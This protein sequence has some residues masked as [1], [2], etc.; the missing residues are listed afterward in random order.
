M[1]FTSIKSVGQPA[2]VPAMVNAGGMT[3]EEFTSYL[4]ETTGSS[5]RAPKIDVEK[6]MQ[7]PTVFAAVNLVSNVVASC[8][9]TLK[10][11]E[12]KNGLRK[13]VMVHE[14]AMLD[15]VLSPN[16]YQSA[17]DFVKLITTHLMLAGGFLAIKQFAPDGKRVVA[18]QPIKPGRWRIATDDSYVPIFHVYYQDRELPYAADKVVYIGNMSL[19]GVSNFTNLD[20]LRSAVGLSNKLSE[21][22]Y[23]Y[24]S[25]GNL[26]NGVLNI[27]GKADRAKLND[28]GREFDSAYSGTT[29]KRTAVFDDTVSFEPISAS[30]QDSQHLENRDHQIAEIA[31]IWNIPP[32]ML[33][34]GIPSQAAKDHFV[35]ECIKPLFSAI[36]Q[37]LTKALKP[38]FS[39]MRRAFF[40]LDETDLLRGSMSE[41]ASYIMTLLGSGGT[42]PVISQNEG[43]DYLNLELSD[44]DHAQ[45]ILMG[46]YEGANQGGLDASVRSLIKQVLAEGK[47]QGGSDAL[48]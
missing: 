7:N 12:S 18:L 26:I 40:D 22:S 46:G 33:G 9:I 37:G 31:S 45:E 20:V 47:P 14:H 48:G 3:I 5:E 2:S 11:V 39:D 19:D 8:P 32:E 16:P 36:E 25:K 10:K 27:K 17:F 6:A 4:I 28:Y 42:P 41:Q 35:S 34:K 38:H 21:L 30:M 13:K 44:A 1:A 29:G 43:R 24:A 23:A 15:L